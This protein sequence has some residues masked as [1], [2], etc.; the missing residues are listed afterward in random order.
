[1]YL[2][3]YSKA[4]KMVTE[5]RL[6]KQKQAI[7]ERKATCKEV[8]VTQR[9]HDICFE[10]G[11]SGCLRKFNDEDVGMVHLFCQLK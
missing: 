7:E 1:M 8:P 4:V 6:E 9:D 3:R 11:F 2:G 10:C 5:E